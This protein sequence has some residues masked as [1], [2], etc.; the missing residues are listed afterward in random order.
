VYGLAPTPADTLEV[1]LFAYPTAPLLALLRAWA[2]SPRPI[3]CLIPEGSNADTLLRESTRFGSLSG[4]QSERKS[5]TIEVVPF[6]DQTLFDE[7]LAGCDLAFV[8]GEES[9]AQVQWHGRPFVWQIYPQ[10]DA[11]HEKK[12]AAFLDLYLQGL[13]EPSANA[14]RSL[15]TA[16][17]GFSEAA[18]LVRAWNA[19]LAHYSAIQAHA[20]AWAER[21]NS[22]GDLTSKLEAFIRER[23]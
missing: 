16:W 7:V 18:D 23:L 10:S 12:L 17:N 13:D 3:R 22:V 15:W 8:R 2:Q 11:A 6:V 20:I 14:I 19:F 9:F 1:F 4:E 5:V 21:V